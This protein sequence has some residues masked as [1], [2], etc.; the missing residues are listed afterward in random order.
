MIKRTILVAAGAALLA[1]A[2]SEPVY[3]LELKLSVETPPRHV[4]NKAAAKWAEEVA[5]ATG[6]D[7]QIKVFPSAQLYKSSGA[8]KALASGALDMSIQANTTYSRF[9]S[10]LSVINLPM[11]YGAKREH[12]RAVLDGPNGQELWS[13][14]SNKLKVHIPGNHFEFAPSNTAFTTNKPIRSYDDLKGVKLATPP[15]PVLVEAL[16]AIGANPVATPRS[17]VT[18]QLTQGQIDGLG[19]VTDFTISGGKFWDAGI[20]YGW[21]DN[22]GWGAYIPLVSQ[23][24]WDGLSDAHKKALTS[25]W[26]AAKSFARNLTETDLS[27]AIELNKRNGVEYASPTAD[28]IAA[29]RKKLLAAQDT[30]VQKT[31]MDAAFVGKVQAQLAQLQR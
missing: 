8:G 28:Q 2:Y 25:G 5:K 13:K 4:R 15:S 10:N 12:I 30:I 21:K 27:K 17:E 24:T 7:V 26:E 6:G 29:M 20:K 11:A 18:L 23:R 22:A 31:R 14:V 19:L 1:S 3:S 16:K 9:E